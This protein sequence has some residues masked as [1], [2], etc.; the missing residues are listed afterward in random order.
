VSKEKAMKIE[1]RFR[2]LDPSEALRAH[3]ARRIHFHLSRFGNEI[4]AVLVRIA[5]VNGPKG[6]VDKRC[7]VTVR[8]PRLGS[9]IL[10]ETS[11]DA[12]SAVD[13]A[14][15]RTGRSVGRELHRARRPQR[16]VNGG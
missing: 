11:G 6:G 16:Q 3:A 14:V 9:T 7:Q 15:E 12:Y 1:V 4:S 10:D 5:D 13:V 8:G 2:G